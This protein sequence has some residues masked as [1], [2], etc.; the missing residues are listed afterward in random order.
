MGHCK[1]NPIEDD[2]ALISRRKIISKHHR[3]DSNK[4]TEYAQNKTG[5]HFGKVWL[6]PFKSPRS[7]FPRRELSLFYIKLPH[8]TALS[9][10]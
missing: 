4:A 9:K 8:H 7:I 10:I 2:K 3:C 1:K 5:E 6:T